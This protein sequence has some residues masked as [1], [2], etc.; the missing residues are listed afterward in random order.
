MYYHCIH[1]LNKLKPYIIMLKLNSII[2]ALVFFLFMSTSAYAQTTIS[3]TVSDSNGPLIGATVVIDGTSQGAVCDGQGK[4]QLSVEPGSYTIKAS[5]AGYKQETKSVSVTVGETSVLDFILTS[6]DLSEVIVTGT[7]AAD[8]TSTDSPVPVDIIDVTELLEVTPQNEL[9]QILTFA[10]PSFSSNTQTIS[11]GTDHIQPAAI[12]GLGPDQVLVLINGKRWHSSSLV[13]V[14]GTFGRGNVS[15]D[16]NAIPVSSIKNIE[17]LRDGASAQYGSDAIAGVINVILKEDVNKLNFSV[18]SGANF[19]SGAS[20][21]RAIDGEVLQ[22][23]ANYG[24]PL[25]KRGYINLT[26]ETNIRGWTNRM[27]SFSGQIFNGYNSIERVASAAG[28]DI[29]ALSLDDV[30]N[31]AQDVGY[32]S[33]DLKS[34]IASA[35]TQDSV[36]SLLNFDATEDELSARGQVRS[37]YNMRV[38][39]SA[40]RGGKFF[41]NL[42]MPLDEKWEAYGYAGISYREGESGCFYR[43]PHQ[44]RAY[45]PIF[46]NGFVPKINS[47]ISDETFAGGIRGK[48]NG[49]NVD[50]SYAHGKNTFLY[51]MT[52]TLNAA[53]QNASPTE[54][55]AGGHSYTQST[56]NIDVARYFRMSSIKGINVAFGAEYRFE[57]YTLARGSERSFGNYDIN[58]ELVTATTSDEALV[59]DFFG[60]ARPS[61][62]QCFAGF[63]PSNEVDARRSN[64]STY[65]DTEFDITDEL[66]LSGALR[67]ED[68]SD[69]G[70]TLNFK[71]AGRYKITDSFI[72]RAGY[73]TGFRAPSLH[74]I[75]FSRT[76]TIFVTEGGVTTAQEVG[77]FSNN[78]RAAKLLGIPQLKQETSQNL[79]A[80]VT[81][82]VDRNLKLTV[83]YYSINTQDRI[84]L[85]GRFRPGDSEELQQIFSQAQA[86]Q[87]NFFANA[88]DVQ[89]S[90]VDVVAS[91]KVPLANNASL[92]NDLAAT[93]SSIKRVGDIKS[94]DVLR[95][96]GL[97]DTY[98]D[99]ASRIY[100]ESAV[101]LTKITLGNSLDLDKF[102][103]Y[104][105]NTYFGETTDANNDPD[106]QVY[107]A[108]VITDLSFSYRF[109]PTF[110][111]VLG[112]NNLLDVYPDMNIE[113]SQS[114][115][116]FLYSR[117]SPQFSLNGRYLFAKLAFTL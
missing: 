82:K 65:L 62:C 55:D 54:F 72:L 63:L 83:D 42:S 110:N 88:I 97:V 101:P 74:Q 29:S 87:A 1:K 64:I 79:S 38:G 104:L 109:S 71:A 81:L 16:L 108:R 59:K 7:R 31:H 25:G 41:A 80:G 19:T 26:G 77:T 33:S 22:L 47:R 86:S 52:E 91:Y 66:L 14:N 39:Q 117:R 113:S 5:Y 84:V 95:T 61:G 99:E 9:N 111:L 44:S 115:G 56:G 53:L 37:D 60:R 10:A 32:F 12:R 48:V 100:L 85:T 58:S 51:H 6:E 11:D 57:N 49:W 67:F 20:P 78:S 45:T 18:R 13:N 70:S 36:A 103:V 94:S 102:S 116:R 24:I 8:R 27:Q 34:L 96:A 75:H 98:F 93:F 106:P 40:V 46:I 92:N 73:S 35:P 90:G 89:A 112:A 3:G 4:Y 28:A 17:V 68:Y 107:G 30:K 43:L 15:S 105:R 21:Q 23:G 69:F 76:S 2:S 50:L 114:S